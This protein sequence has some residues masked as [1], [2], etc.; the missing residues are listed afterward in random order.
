MIRDFENCALENG[1]E[2][3]SHDGKYG[4][5]VE[6]WKRVLSLLKEQEAK[7]AWYDSNDLL[8]YWHCGHCGVIITHGD[9]YCRMCGREVKWELPK[10]E[11]DRD[12]TL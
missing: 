3:C 6:L 5:C 11:G 4:N 7:A 9:K 8:R 1:C 12:G 2:K 10:E